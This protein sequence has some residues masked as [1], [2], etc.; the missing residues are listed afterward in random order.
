MVSG[1]WWVKEGYLVLFVLTVKLTLFLFT[2]TANACTR[3]SG[4]VCMCCAL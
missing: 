3:V 4:L 1:E 2:F